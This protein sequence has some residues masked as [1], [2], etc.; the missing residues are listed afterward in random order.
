MEP[1]SSPQA[2][3]PHTLC[4]WRSKRKGNGRHCS[5][6]TV[7]S[8]V[9]AAGVSEV[10]PG[11]PCRRFADLYFLDT[12]MRNVRCCPKI[13]LAIAGLSLRVTA[14]ISL[15]GTIFQPLTG[16]PRLGG[17][18]FDK[19]R[20]H[21]T[22]RSFSTLRKSTLQPST[23]S[24]SS[25]QM[26]RISMPRFKP[27]F[28]LSPYPLKCKSEGLKQLS[29]VELGLRDLERIFETPLHLEWLEFSCIGKRDISPCQMVQ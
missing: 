9:L 5:T 23:C 11:C 4:C 17:D 29:V 25:Y 12:L 18:P 2:H 13:I 14:G 19:D 22:S 26:P 1:S 6:C 20:S 8:H 21:F 28:S 16:H 10:G 24:R 27:L 7:P 3:T 15:D